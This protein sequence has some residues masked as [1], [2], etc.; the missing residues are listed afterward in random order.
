MV[1]DI[2][3][4][5]MDCRRVAQAAV[6]QHLGGHLKALLLAVY[7][8]VCQDGGELFLGKV[9]F[10][11]HI[12]DFPDQDF[13]SLGD[14]KTSLFRDPA[15]GLAHNVRVEGI[16]LGLRESVCNQLFLLLAGDEIAAVVLHDG[17]K[18]GGDILIDDDRLFGGA[19]HAV[20]K[21]F[22]EH[23]VVAGLG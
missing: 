23:Q 1:D 22:G 12:R 17:L 9:V 6:M 21:G 19:D 3:V 10:R 13:G 15:G 2:G 11:A 14:G 7:Y 20:V 8:D 18:G 5:G 16:A 4:G